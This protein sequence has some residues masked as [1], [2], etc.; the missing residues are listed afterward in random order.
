M[1]AVKSCEH[2]N[3]G[4]GGQQLKLRKEQDTKP[5]K[6]GLEDRK[7]TGVAWGLFFVLVGVSLAL[8]EIQKLDPW[9]IV[10][11][12]LGLILV[13]LNLA[14]KAAGLGFGRFTFIV[15][16]VAL[17]VGLGPLVRVPIPLLPAVIVLVGLFIVAETL[18]R[19]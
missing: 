15:G 10:A 6:T 3:V 4:R 19:R 16:I 8:Q 18:R 2:A 12:G 1:V 9:P 17:L 5:R 11:L 7:L 13:G 14:R